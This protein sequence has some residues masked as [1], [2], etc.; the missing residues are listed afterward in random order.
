MAVFE[1]V[2]ISELSEATIYSSDD[3]PVIIPS[4]DLRVTIQNT[5]GNIN[6]Y[7]NPTMGELE[8]LTRLEVSCR[9]LRGLE[10]LPNLKE[11]YQLYGLRSVLPYDVYDLRHNYKMGYLN[12]TSMNENTY[13]V[14]IHMNDGSAELFLTGVMRPF[15]SIN[16]ILI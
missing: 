10:L 13:Q 12:L 8:L 14:N 11:L 15:F 3:T 16:H 6:I 5:L 9:D 4:L 7:S 2:G 1:G